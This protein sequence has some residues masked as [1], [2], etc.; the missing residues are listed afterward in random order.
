MLLGSGY[1]LLHRRQRGVVM[2]IAL[3]TLV[4][5]TLTGLAL[6]RTVDSGVLVAGNMAMKSSALR[7]GDAGIQAAANWLYITNANTPATLAATNA[8]G[9]YSA[10]GLTD[11]ISC[12]GQTW[13]ACWNTLS[14]VYTPV[15]LATDGAGNTVQYVIQRLC[16]AAGRC[17]QS[18][19]G[20]DP[21][22]RDNRQR[23]IGPGSTYYRILARISGPRGTVSL[24][25]AVVA[26]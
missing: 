23:L 16:D 8:G 9:G 4:V 20:L 17:S 19:Q 12:A 13:T 2:F 14:G 21:T 24:I 15:S 11:D 3:I 10:F 5:L 22:N 7:S 26:P 25:Q 6:M 18:P 1:P